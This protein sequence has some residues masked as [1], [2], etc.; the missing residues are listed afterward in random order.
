MS[1]TVTARMLQELQARPD[2]FDFVTV[3]MGG[4][5]KDTTYEMG[6]QR[7]LFL[8]EKWVKG[9]PL[10]IWEGSHGYARIVGLQ[11][12]EKSQLGEL[13]D[14]WYADP[15]IKSGGM[16]GAMHQF[17]LAHLKVIHEEG[18]DEWLKMVKKQRNED[19]IRVRM[20]P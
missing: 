9:K 20:W 18:H 8:G 7:M 2:C 16:T 5:G 4:F 19:P 3:E 13:E 11:S 14:I 6:M 17:V 10:R 15:F 12:T 1:G